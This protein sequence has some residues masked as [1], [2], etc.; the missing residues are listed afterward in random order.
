MA[1]LPH[2]LSNVLAASNGGAIHCQ[3][4][5]PNCGATEPPRRR[6]RWRLCHAV[7]VFRRP[8]QRAELRLEGAMMRNCEPGLFG[9]T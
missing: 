5:Q 8:A 9:P 7:A 1:L 4:G 2:P 3:R 6:E